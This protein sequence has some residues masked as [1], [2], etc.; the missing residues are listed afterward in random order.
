M[1]QYGQYNTFLGVIGTLTGNNP[2]PV[3]PTLG[4]INIIGAAGVTVTGFPAISTL[5]ISLGGAVGTQFQA[6]DLNIAVPI[7]NLLEIAGSTNI[8]TTAA[9]N[10]VYINLN[11]S[12]VF[13]N[14]NNTG[15]EGMYF[16]GASRFM[17]NYGLRNTWLGSL[18]G[19]LSLTVVTAINNTGIGYDALGL[20]STGHDNLAAGKSAGSSLHTGNFNVFLGSESGAAG[21]GNVHCVAVGYNTLAD[22]QTSFDIVAIGSNA[23]ATSNGSNS[24]VAIGKNSQTLV[25]VA[26]YNTSCGHDT[27][28]AIDTGSFNTVY[29]YSSG[30]NLTL[31]DGCNVLIRNTGTVGD[32]NTIR[33]GTQGNG[34]GEQDTC[35]VA[36]IYGSTVASATASVTMADATGKLG[37]ITPGT[38]GQLLIGATGA[39]PAWA[40]LT[41]T[42]GAIVITN[43]ANT[44][45]LEAQGGGVAW[46][47]YT[48]AAVPLVPGNGYIM[49]RGTL[50]TATL[51]AAAAI[52]SFISIVGKGAGLYT[53]VQNAGQIIHFDDQDTTLTTGSLTAT[54]RYDCIELVCIVTDTEWVVR[55]SVGNFT[56]I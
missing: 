48:A 51:P 7:A 24:C 32:N 14:T 16:L 41:S 8:N 3:G 46:A 43:G 49:N 6:D 18:A 55:S 47:E 44:I 45:N 37:V 52:G 31:A 54:N 10:H 56:I 23:L 39:T 50:I 20:I 38:N 5:Q 9:T 4:N 53:I 40:N 34:N 29:G 2:G 33:I 1:S 27:L 36:G 12:L 13:P 15:T 17:H 42:V 25:S 26:S 19:N 21:L 28:S 22:D 30:S 35:Y 11:E